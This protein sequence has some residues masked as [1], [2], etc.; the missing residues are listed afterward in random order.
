MFQL[1]KVIPT[2]IWQKRKFL[3]YLLLLSSLIFVL[4]FPWNRLMEK[5]IRSLQK[6]SPPHL[7]TDFESLAFVLWPP[8]LDFKGFS[9]NYRKKTIQVES[10][11]ISPI[12]SHWI[13]FKPAWGFR[14]L[15]GKSSL[16]LR[17]WKEQRESTENPEEPPTDVFFIKAYSLL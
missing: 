6:K 3:I 17:F 10:L 5:T 1:L 8:G 9:L 14:A 7:Q 11:K 16:A 13:A 15:K 2:F 4:R 12:L